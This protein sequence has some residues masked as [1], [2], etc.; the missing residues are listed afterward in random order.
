MDGI[1]HPLEVN[2]SVELPNR[3]AEGQGTIVETPSE[4]PVTVADIPDLTV[5]LTSTA[6]VDALADLPAVLVGATLVQGWRAVAKGAVDVVGSLVLLAV[7][8]LPLLVPARFS[9][10]RSGWA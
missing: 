3:K 1:R 5:G 2:G 7:F 4:L 9:T 6:R 8:G 10:G